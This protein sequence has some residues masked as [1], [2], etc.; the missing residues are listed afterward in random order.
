[1]TDIIPK[2]VDMEPHDRRRAIAAAAE[3][4]AEYRV[5][6]PSKAT[7]ASLIEDTTFAAEDRIEEIRDEA[8]KERALEEKADQLG[9]R[10]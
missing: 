7:L 5:A 10:Y 8:A 2:P 1:M 4:L 3:A 6:W 9:M